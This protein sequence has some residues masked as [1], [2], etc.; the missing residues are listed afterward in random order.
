MAQV[1][2]S[3][4]DEQVD[5]GAIGL[6]PPRR[7]TLERLLSGENPRS[8]T[9]SYEAIIESI[10]GAKDDSQPV[11]RYDG[12][13]GVSEAF[14]NSHQRPVGQLQWDA[15]LA[16]RYDDPGNV[17]GVRWCT[18]TLISHNLFLTAGHCFDEN[19]PNG[20]VLPRQNGTA[21]PISTEEIAAAMHVNFNY[22]V[23]R[24]GEL[25]TES[26]FEIDELVE[27]RSGGLD[28]AI[29][30]LAGNPG[31]RF[32]MGSPAIAD[33]QVDDMLAIIGHP[34]GVPKR[35]ETGSVSR[36]EGD[37]IRYDGID[38]IGGNS[39][40]AI[41]H[42]RSGR[43][44]GVHTDGGCNAN[45]GSNFG[46]R[47]ERI[48]EESPTIHRLDHL[49]F[50][51]DG[52]VYSIRQL[53]SN[54]LLDAHESTGNDFSAVTRAQQPDRVASTQSWRFTPAGL[55]LKLRQVSSDRYL[56]GHDDLGPDFSA[57]T[58][59]NQ[60]SDDQKWVA[61]PVPGLLSTYTLQQLS[62]GRLLDAHRSPAADFSV[63]T[64][65]R[66]NRDTQWW[67]L[68][69]LPT[70]SFTI[71]QAAT[72]RSLDAYHDAPN[73]FTA[74]TRPAQN[75]GAQRWSLTTVG[76]VYD[77]EQVS[78]G[79]RLDGH[80]NQVNDFSAVTRAV[81]NE[82]TQRWVATYLGGQA[83]TLQQLSSGRYLDAHET[84][85]HD[86]SAVTRTRQENDTQRWIIG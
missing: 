74:V 41:W 83:Y 49:A 57:V 82:D 76:A 68:A 56:D 5:H 3:S 37:R 31:T 52:G 30:R 44:V 36:F 20:W 28:I 60:D 15:I 32:G 11:E 27:Y 22:Q 66:Q 51:L 61:L 29:V 17:S 80:E 46:V 70:G 19:P 9:A 35:V 65:L 21:K 71:S 10:C 23:D 63:V 86:F 7:E 58:R 73:D 24:H 45:G 81:Q 26:S 69:P 25:R 8:R 75:S 6:Y 33:P 43:I 50:P 53:S 14:V 34:A 47:V 67:Q 40:S 62:S 72:G 85:E 55:V 16:D 78:S 42:G 4:G 38:T 1:E 64:R 79:R 13:L 77:I 12:G 18:G 2:E 48:R 84:D 54:R 59:G 39:G